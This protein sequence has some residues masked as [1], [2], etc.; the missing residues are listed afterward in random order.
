MLDLRELCVY[1]P[2]LQILIITLAIHQSQQAT[3]PSQS[4]LIQQTPPVICTEHAATSFASTPYSIQNYAGDATVSIL[5]NEPIALRSINLAGL[6][7]VLAAESNVTLGVR[8]LHT[9]K[10]DES[11]RDLLL[12]EV[13]YLQQCTASPI[14]ILVI[15]E[16][17]PIVAEIADDI[18]YDIWRLPPAWRLLFPKVAHLLYELP[19]NAGQHDEKRLIDVQAADLLVEEEFLGAA[20][21]EHLCLDTMLGGGG[22]V[23][24][25]GMQIALG[26]A[27]WYAQNG[28]PNVAKVDDE[29]GTT[30][31]TTSAEDQERTTS[32]STLFA[33]P[34][35]AEDY[36]FIASE[37]DF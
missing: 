16:M 11:V 24:A 21:S 10:L 23:D 1:F 9:P 31:S 26:R 4:A 34:L 19:W 8:I 36:A 32:S 3:Q 12:L 7:A 22:T 35:V 25:Y 5:T 27:I 20:R 28:A 17:W 30:V 37:Y 6:N 13:Q 33:V 18:E 14:A 15:Y 2:A 29:I